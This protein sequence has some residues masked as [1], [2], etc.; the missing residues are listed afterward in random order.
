MAQAG[1]CKREAVGSIGLEEMK[2]FIFSFICSG[3]Y[4]LL[5]RGVESAT[6]D[7]IRCKV[8]SGVS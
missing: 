7:A 2:Y 6:Q 1:N 4:L 5:V 8:G 3:V